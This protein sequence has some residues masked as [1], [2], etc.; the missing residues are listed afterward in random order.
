MADCDKLKSSFS[1]YLDGE[2]P[3]NQRK[4]LDEHFGKCAGCQDTLRQ[5][6]IIQRSLSQLPQIS[7]T[8]QFEQRLHQ[9]IFS[10]NSETRLIPQS[11]LSWKL[12]A[13]GSALVLATVGLFL[14]LFDSPD[15]GNTLPDKMNIPVNTAAPQIPA[16][17]PLNIHK[18]P[19]TQVSES[20]GITGDSVRQDS[21]F[22][23][24]EAIRQIS[25]N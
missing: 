18:T 15:P 9:Q 19:T 10:Q 13:M 20:T 17:S 5:M 16:S 25:G 7:T 1:D 24:T 3:H 21:L 11:F 4:E 12:P 14:V 2:I 22:L 6:R 8:P 23:D